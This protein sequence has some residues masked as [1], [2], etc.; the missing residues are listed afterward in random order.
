MRAVGGDDIAANRATV[1]EGEELKPDSQIE[2]GSAEGIPGPATFTVVIPI[3][4]SI[5]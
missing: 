3:Y 4:E 2:P 1:M 5:L